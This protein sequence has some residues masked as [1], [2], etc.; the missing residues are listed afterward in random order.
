MVVFINERSTEPAMLNVKLVRA[1]PS[2]FIKLTLFNQEFVAMVRGFMEPGANVRFGA[3]AAE[4]P[5]TDPVSIIP[6]SFVITL[7]PPAP[8]YVKFVKFD[9]SIN[10][11]PNVNEFVSMLFVPKTIERTL[12]LLLTN[13]PQLK[14]LPFKSRVPEVNVTVAKLYKNPDNVVVPETILTGQFKLLPRADTVPV[15]VNSPVWYPPKLSPIKLLVIFREPDP[16]VWPNDPVPLKLTTDNGVG[17][18]NS[19]LGLP[20]LLSTITESEGVVNNLLNGSNA[21]P[22]V[23]AQF[24]VLV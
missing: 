6:L 12:V 3:F 21:A 14:S 18:V 10:V 16:E 24:A 23:A 5:A 13:W 8:E 1:P 22:L 2:K 11:S 19:I 7:N 17:L 9:I 20:E 4:P 15:K